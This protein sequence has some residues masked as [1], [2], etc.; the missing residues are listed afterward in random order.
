MLLLVDCHMCSGEG[1]NDCED[2]GVLTISPCKLTLYQHFRMEDIIHKGI[3]IFKPGDSF[4]AHIGL[5]GIYDDGAV[6]AQRVTGKGYNPY[7][8]EKTG[9]IMDYWL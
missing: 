5:I 3:C 8:D 9:K 7:C 2:K 4:L 6:K 1:C